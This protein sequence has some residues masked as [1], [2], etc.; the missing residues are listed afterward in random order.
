MDGHDDELENEE[1]D[2]STDDNDGVN[3]TINNTS[4]YSVRLLL[5]NAR[6]LKPKIGSLVEAFQS[7]NLNAAS[8]TETWFKGGKGLRD[9]LRDLEGRSGIRVLHKSR[10]GRSNKRGGG[11]ALA[12]RTAN[13]NFRARNLKQMS[14]GFEVL[15]AVGKVA[16]IERSI[17]I[18]VVYIPPDMRAP[19][20]ETLKE[21]LSAEIVAVQKSY[22]NPLIIVNGDMNRRDLGSGINEVADFDLVRTGPTRGDS[23][24]DL[25]FINAP[26][27]VDEAIVTPPLHNSSGVPSDHRSV[28]V[29]ATIP[30]ERKF[31]WVV[32]WRRTRDQGREEAFARELRNWD[33][34]GL[35]GLPTVDAMALELRKVIDCLTDR[36]FPLARVRKRSNELPWI[37]KRIRWLWKKKIRIYK[38]K[39]QI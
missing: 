22:K 28:F 1:S 37:T 23:T 7:L 31:R 25:M 20:L 34:S 26:E 12:F 24:I 9:D 35:P 27:T 18:F 39:R 30:P 2:C 13:S 33:W 15:C 21:E 10:D 36:H 16:K 3:D 5:T 8:V 32:Q 6:S 17:V 19:A 4:E 11:V 29:R 38:K 14:K